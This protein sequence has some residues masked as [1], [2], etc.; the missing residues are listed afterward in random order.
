MRLLDRFGL[1]ARTTLMIDD[2]KENLETASRLGIQTILFR[3]SRQ[4]RAEL[5]VADVLPRSVERALGKCRRQ[6]R[7]PCPVWSVAD[8]PMCSETTCRTITLT[9]CRE[10]PGQGPP[11]RPSSRS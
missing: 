1:T 8:A 5:E 6:C 10:S 3:S 2:T 9:A 7:V 4:L 11:V